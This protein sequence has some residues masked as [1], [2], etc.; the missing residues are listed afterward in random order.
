MF[1]TIAA[2]STIAY[3]VIFVVLFYKDRESRN[4]ESSHHPSR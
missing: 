4:E 2:L 3:V 1:E